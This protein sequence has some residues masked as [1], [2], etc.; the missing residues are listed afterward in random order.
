[1]IN[2]A[3]RPS[4]NL[5]DLII[6]EFVLRELQSMFDV[7]ADEI[8]RM[9]THQRLRPV[10]RKLAKEA[11]HVFVGGSNL[12]S[13]YM[14]GY[15]QWDLILSDALRVRNAILMGAG[16][17]RDQG[18]CNR[19]TKCLLSAALSWRGWH[20]VRDSQALKQLQQIGFKRVLNT[21]CPTMWS[22]AQKDTASLRTTRASQALLML[23]DYDRDETNDRRLVD[24]LQS[25]YSQVYFWPQGMADR[26]Y[27]LELG[28]RGTILDRSLPGL[29]ELL[30]SED[31]LD[32]IGTRLHGGI[33]CLHRDKRILIIEVD[34]RARE[35][36]KDTRLPTVARGD[37]ETIE[38]WIQQSDPVELNLPHE[39][40]AQW[41]AQ[42]VG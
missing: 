33:R 38:S 42:F 28:F 6:E 2:Q 15:F 20:S 13:S 11:D 24:L 39:N 12:L 27:A 32:Y 17:W 7:T 29:D 3:L 40:I 9:A 14:D 4:P 22:L 37:F 16:W 1:M 18:V 5:G 36:G 21:G 25:S 23:T 35:I 10:E 34:N 19:Y 8:P 31:D 30:A 26:D 41:K